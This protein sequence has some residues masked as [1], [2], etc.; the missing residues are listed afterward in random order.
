MIGGGDCGIWGQ[1]GESDV[2]KMR[3]FFLTEAGSG[4]ESER[5][6]MC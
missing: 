2:E 5:E 6:K 4:V 1:C 3:T